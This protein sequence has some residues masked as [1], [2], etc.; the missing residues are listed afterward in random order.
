MALVPGETKT[1][2]C[3]PKSSQSNRH[4]H[5]KTVVNIVLV[6]HGGYRSIHGRLGAKRRKEAALP[7]S[8]RESFTKVT[9]GAGIK[10]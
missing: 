7:R 1:N 9:S 5:R 6:C 3:C 8:F 4:V 10:G 2:D